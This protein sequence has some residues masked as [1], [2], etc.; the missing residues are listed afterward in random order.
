MRANDV[1]CA[2]VLNAR[3]QAAVFAVAIKRPHNALTPAKAVTLVN[4][5]AIKTRT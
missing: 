3:R 2:V 4:V 5:P 1:F